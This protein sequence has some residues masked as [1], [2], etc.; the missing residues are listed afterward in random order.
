MQEAPENYLPYLVAVNLTKRCN[1]NCAHCYMNAEQRAAVTAGEMEDGEIVSLFQEIGARAP[2]TIL[3]L[4]G[5]EPLL[6]P[7]LESLVKAG[8]DAGLRMVLGTNGVLLT[9]SM[10]ARLKAAGLEGMGISLDSTNPKSHDMFRGQDGAFAKSCKAVRICKAAGMH[11]QIHFTVTRW[12]RSEIAGAVQMAKDLGAA[13]LNFFFLVCVGRGEGR[14]DLSPAEYESA[15]REIA[16]LQKSSQGIMVQSRCTPHFKRILIESDPENPY[17]RATGYDGGGCPAA[18]HYCRV[19]PKGEVTPCPYIELSGGN[20]RGEGFWK[21][22]DKS[23]LFQSLR[24]PGLLEGRCGSCEFKL[25]CGGCRARALVDNGNLMGE[26]P[27]CEYVPKGGPVLQAFKPKPSEE[28]DWT[29]EA[30]ARLARIP[31]FLRPV[32]KKKLEARAREEHVQV[33]V[34]LMQKHRQERERDLGIKF[35]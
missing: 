27:N 15:L 21:V 31:M 4:T 11:A 24:N 26:D 1:L 17:T 7:H 22:W 2:G 35:N 3:V 6:H 18:T 19:T 16:A 8:V 34:E 32:I 33:T 20:I 14:M 29:P 30:K 23:R 28:V 9:E 10:A 12:N 5:G 13:I 25:M